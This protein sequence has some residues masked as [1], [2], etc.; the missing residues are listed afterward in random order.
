MEEQEKRFNELYDRAYTR[1]TR[2]YTGF[3]DLDG[4]RILRESGLPCEFYGGYDGAERAVAAFGDGSGFPIA[5]VEA[6][7]KAEKFADDLTHRDFLGALM[8]LGIDRAVTG[9]II[10]SGKTAYIVCLG[11]MAEYIAS[12]LTSVRHTAVKCRVLAQVPEVAL[13]APEKTEFV[14]SS[15][16]LDAVVAAVWKLSRSEAQELFREG[17]VFVDAKEETRPDR[18]PRAGEIVSVR[19]RGRFRYTGTVRE[20]KKGRLRASAEV[21]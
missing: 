12:E 7:P 19:G 17:R 14:I 9:D 6:A 11:Q 15:E 2:E 1:G 13:P 5:C 10:V 21:W 20:T 18:E 16:R 8:S 4:Q 3:L